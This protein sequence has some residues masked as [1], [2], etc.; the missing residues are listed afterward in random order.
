[1]KNKEEQDKARWATERWG[2]TKAI[3]D[4]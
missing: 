1:M 4:Q 3:I 2:E